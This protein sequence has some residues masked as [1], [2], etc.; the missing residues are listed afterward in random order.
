MKLFNPIALPLINDQDAEVVKG[1]A[2]AVEM[3]C[4]WLLCPPVCD[5]ITMAIQADMNSCFHGLFQRGLAG[6]V[7]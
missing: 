7:R 1:V 4:Y 6:A 2:C 3:G 5:V